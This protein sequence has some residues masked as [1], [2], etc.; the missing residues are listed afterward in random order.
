MRLYNDRVTGGKGGYGDF[1]GG[2]RWRYPCL[3]R[4]CALF[5][6]AQAE[7]ED[8]RIEDDFTTLMFRFNR[9]IEEYYRKRGSVVALH[10]LLTSCRDGLARKG[11]Q[12]VEE[13]LEMEGAGRPPVR[14][15]LLAGGSIGR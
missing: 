13:W 6:Q 15:C 9:L 3:A 7:I 11:L 4:Y 1:P 14:Y 8:A 12:R 2:E 10:T 5:S